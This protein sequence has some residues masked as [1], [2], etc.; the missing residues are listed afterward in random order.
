MKLF[1]VFLSFLLSALLSW[2]IIPRIL[3]VTY[4]KKLFDLPDERKIHTEAIPRLGGLSF[5]PSLAI[6]ISFTVGLRYLT[7]YDILYVQKV[8][9]EFSF[10]ICGLTLLYLIGVRDDLVGLRYREKFVF[11]IIAAS[12]ITLSGLWINNLYGLFGI[13][14]LPAWLGIP[15]TVLLIV[16]ITNAINLIDGIDGLASGLSMVAL[17]ILGILFISID[18]WLYATLAF[19]TFGLLLPFFYFNV[20]GKVEKRQK[21]FMGDTGSLTLGFILAFLSIR[22]ASFDPEMIPYSEGTLIMAFSPLIIPMFDVVRVVCVRMKNRK[23]LFIADRSH[24]HHKFLDM[25]FSQRQAMVSII[26]IACVFSLVNILVEPYV[27]INILFV[28]DALAWWG[29]HLGVNSFIDEK[30]KIK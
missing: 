9:A 13:Y 10:L 18:L 14:E 6:S 5:A 23:G 15:F 26:L 7:G 22:L 30:V 28:G 24:I 29:V 11:Q 2:F 25:G 12:L 20:F 1:F 16:F 19:A 27:N 4:K 21:I 3:V 8:I 17:V